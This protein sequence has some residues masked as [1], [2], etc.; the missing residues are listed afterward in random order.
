MSSYGPVNIIKIKNDSITTWFDTLKDGDYSFEL[1]GYK[2]EKPKIDKSEYMPIVAEPLMAKKTMSRFENIEEA[3]DLNKS[4]CVYGRAGTGKTYNTKM[5]VDSINDILLTSIAHVAVNNLT[6]KT[7]VQAIT[8]AKLF[9]GRKRGVQSMISS[10]VM[11]HEWILI[12]EFS[13]I[14]TEFFEYLMMLSHYGVKLILVGDMNQCTPPDSSDCIRFRTDC[15]NELVDGYVHLEHIYRYDEE[16][17][18]IC[19]ELL[20]SGKLV[21][22]FA[23]KS[24]YFNLCFVN[25]TRKRLNK[26]I[27]EKRMKEDKNYLQIGDLVLHKGECYIICH[28]NTDKYSN[29]QV[30]EVV[31]FDDK[32][33]QMKDISTGEE[34]SETLIDIGRFFYMGYCITTHKAQGLTL[35]MDYTIHDVAAM[36]RNLIYTAITRAKTFQQVSLSGNRKDVYEPFQRVFQQTILSGG[37]PC[38]FVKGFIYKLVEGENVFYVGQTDNLKERM[39]QHQEMRK[40]KQF[41][42]VVIKEL[43]FK[44][45]YELNELEEQAVNFYTDMGFTL[46]NKLLYYKPV[47]KVVKVVKAKEIDFKYTDHKEKSELRW[48]YTDLSGKRKEIAVKYKKIGLE[49]GVEKLKQKVKEYVLN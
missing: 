16:L 30:F 22:D 4:F 15:F 39:K 11:Q 31:G 47:K 14:T 26:A 38:S 41:N 6:E 34:L 45:K 18:V 33:V 35:S 9:E 7:G 5:I 28:E 36:D 19:D 23:T 2:R 40:G 17:R 32:N 48:R 8:M 29:N 49:A 13:Q 1:G 24:N 43:H 10:I 12:D 3:L 42:M 44:N 25:N 27:I 37:Y 21:G 46:E 20:T